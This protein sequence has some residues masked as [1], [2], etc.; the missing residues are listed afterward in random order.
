MNNKQS[1]RN[2]RKNDKMEEEKIKEMGE[3]ITK[4]K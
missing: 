2:I 3:N 1:T 4:A